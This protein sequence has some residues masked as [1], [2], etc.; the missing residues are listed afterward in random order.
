MIFQAFYRIILAAQSL[1]L[2]TVLPGSGLR[3]TPNTFSLIHVIL[4]LTCKEIERA[5]QLFDNHKMHFAFHILRN[6]VHVHEC[7][8]LIS[9]VIYLSIYN[10][11]YTK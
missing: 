8:V 2:T 11:Y 5:G 9:K 1:T 10:F 3:K 4:Q 6:T 7:R